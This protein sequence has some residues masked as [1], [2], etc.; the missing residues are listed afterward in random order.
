[1]TQTDA[2]GRATFHAITPQTGVRPTAREIRWL[3]HIERHGPQSSQYL[4]ELTL[5]THRCKDTSLRQMQKLRA[6]GYLALPRQQLMTEHA[7]FN[8]HIYDLT[9][10]AKTHLTD[11]GIA[12][13]TV[14]PTGHW[15]HGYMTSC[16]TSSIDIAAAREGVRYIP[17]HEILSIKYAPLSIPVGTRKL[18][19]D[20]LFALDYGGSYRVFAL[21]VDRGTEPITSGAAR[22]SLKSSVEMYAEVIGKG[23]YRRHYGLKANLLVLWVFASQARK[24]RFLEAVSTLRSN[25]EPSF[26]SKS[27]STNTNQTGPICSLFMSPWHRVDGSTI[28]VNEC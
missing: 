23:V 20:Q 17:A 18:I 4:Y 12:E 5:D 26:L 21:E 25:S 6:G 11:L 28:S 24:G 15:W 19:P 22:K 1:M 27:I 10:K 3:K 7:G 8:P 14:R 16:V 13:P 2:L 9:P